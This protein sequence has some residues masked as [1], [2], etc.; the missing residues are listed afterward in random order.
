MYSFYTVT[1]MISTPLIVVGVPATQQQRGNYDSNA[2]GGGRFSWQAGRR[3]RRQEQ[4]VNRHRFKTLLTLL[5]RYAY[6][7]VTKVN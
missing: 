4:L 7:E 1:A 3:G 2:L 5:K 6:F